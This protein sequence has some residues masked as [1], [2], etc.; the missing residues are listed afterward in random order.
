MPAP[1]GQLVNLTFS[2]FVGNFAAQ[3]Y[4]APQPQVIPTEHIPQYQQVYEE[5][6]QFNPEQPSTFVPSFYAEETI[7][8]AQMHYEP[9][10]N[11]EQPHPQVIRF[12]INSKFLWGIHPN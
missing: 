11:Y 5:G 1:Y 12:I 9:N 8:A 4:Q 7:N 6:R 2:P 10:M 3:N